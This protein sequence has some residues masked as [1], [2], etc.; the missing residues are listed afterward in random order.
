M[1]LFSAAENK[2]APP[3]TPLDSSKNNSLLFSPITTKSVTAHNKIV[4]AP[5][6]M[7]SAENGYMNDFHLVHHGSFALKG[8]GSIIM[9]ATAVEPRGRVTPHDVGLWEDGQIAPI[10]KVV[11]FIKAQG[12]VPGLQLNHGGRK[13]SMGSP[14]AEVRLLLEHEG[15][16]SQDVVGPSDLPVDEHHAIPRPLT[17]DEMLQLK[18]KWVDA[19]LRADK[20]GIEILQI[21]SAHGYLLH[22]FLSGNTN[23]RTDQYGGSLENRLR[24]PLEVIKAVRDAWPAEKSFWVRLSSTD[25]KNEGTFTKDDDGWDIYQSIEY[26]KELKKIGVD[27]IDCS[28]GGI[29]PGVKYPVAPLWQVPFSEIIKKEAGIATGAVGVITKGSEGES[30]LQEN[31][32][33]FVCVGRQFLRDS[34]FAL[35]AA[36]ELDISVKWPNQFQTGRQ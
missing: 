35:T 25:H 5:M 7:F 4:V 15:G 33:D 12:S 16:W 2:S 3:G 17:M 30:I 26:A 32:A 10:K 27:V 29:L 31:K 13:A 14:F 21:H 34:G 22:S 24:Y 20:A 36:R 18:Q 8:A 6:G 19:A 1:T 9:E 11:D 23:K 28:S